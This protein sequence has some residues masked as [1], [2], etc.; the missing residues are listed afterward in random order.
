MSK[1]V[2]KNKDDAEEF[3]N[4]FW[5]IYRKKLK[6]EYLEMLDEDAVVITAS[7]KMLLGGIKDI[8]K[9]K[10]FI[11]SDFNIDKGKFDFLC[12]GE[13]KV[14]EFEKRFPNTVIDEF[15]TDSKSDVPMMKLAKKV[16]IVKKRR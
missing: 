10:N 8:L 6:R 1:V 3:I 14:R 5:K 12:F 9:T 15:Y 11:C 2:V 7:P 13:N 16:I 4:D